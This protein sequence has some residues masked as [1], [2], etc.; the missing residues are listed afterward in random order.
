MPS[1]FSSSSARHPIRLAVYLADQNPGYD[2]SFGISRMSQMA[3]SGLDQQKDFEI[4]TIVSTTSQQAPTGVGETL[5]LPW[6]TR[7][8]LMRLLTD[9]IHPLL[10]PGGIKPDV[11][12]FPKGFL[13]LL[14]IFCQPSVV[15]I[16]DTILQY[17][18]DHYP[19]WR[20]RWEYKYWARMLKHTLRRADCILTVSKSSE[21]QIR[22][23]MARHRIRD[24]EIVV[25]YESCA[26]EVVPQP[27]EPPKENYVIH[28][29]SNEPHKRTAHLVRWWH[30]AESQG[31]ELPMLHLIG[32]VP[33][34]V[35]PLL[36]SSRSMMKRPFLE[37][38]ALQAA[39]QSARALILPSEIEGFGLPAL[40]AYYLGTPVCFVKGTS[41]EEI[42]GVT[43]QNGG[44]SL[45]DPD[46]L[47][48]SLEQVMSMEPEEVR[49][50]GLKLRETYASEKV[51]GKMAEIFRAMAAR[52]LG[53]HCESSL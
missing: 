38:S 1:T 6:G 19:K 31:R 17:G 33:E 47:F 43:T 8:K 41:V 42:L 29:A 14:N 34:E 44:F 37:E 21:K 39:Y 35:A 48:R 15:T 50:H 52:G 4:E 22:E 53:D 23:F 51:Y 26:Y 5:E 10:S 32:S 20:S 45:D 7:R 12:Y 27:T 9:H 40:E 36:A 18:E 16:H 25:T 11:F 30:E 49:Q 3:L 2:R 13:P 28:L 24:K 46:S